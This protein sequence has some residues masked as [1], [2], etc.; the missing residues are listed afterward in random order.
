[1]SILRFHIT[2]LIFGNVMFH[3]LITK[4]ISRTPKIKIKKQKII[5]I[6]AGIISAKR[7]ALPRSPISVLK[8][9]LMLYPREDATTNK[10]KHPAHIFSDLKAD[11]ETNT[12]G[13]IKNRIR[14][15]PKNTK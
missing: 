10:K 15:R 12:Q 5:I 7:F 9:R 1:M 13:R 6:S 11:D 14:P 3:F 2:G 8:I 4:I